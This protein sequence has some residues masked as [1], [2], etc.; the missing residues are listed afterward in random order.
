MT[1]TKIFAVFASVAVALLVVAAPAMARNRGVEVRTYNNATVETSASAYSY[2]GNNTQQVIAQND[3]NIDDAN[4]ARRI[5]T[6][7]AHST[8]TA[9]STVNT[10]DIR[11]T[12]DCE[13]RGKVK[14][15]TRNRADVSTLADALSDTGMNNQNVYVDGGDSNIDNADG[16]RRIR[17][18]MATSDSAADSLVNSN[19]IRVNRVR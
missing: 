18:G 10:N 9:L 6:G 8:A 15:R 4:G 19:T 11:V 12:A 7:Q 14:V 13:C 1:K 2:T 16:R 5:R 3:G 17:T